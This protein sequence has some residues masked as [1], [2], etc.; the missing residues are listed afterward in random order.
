MKIKLCILIM[1]LLSFLN[2]GAI[3]NIQMTKNSFD[4][5]ETI[6]MEESEF[7]ENGVKLQYK[8][9]NTIDKEFDR[10]KMYLDNNIS[11]DY[12]QCYENQIDCF[13]DNFDINMKLW[14]DSIYTYNEITLI[15]KNPKYKIIDLKNILTKME[16][17]NLEDVQYF[18]YYEGEIKEV[19]NRE[20][21]GKIIDQTN[22]QKANILDINNGCTG[23]GYLNNGDKVNFALTNYN[24]GSY[25]IIG[26][27]IIFATY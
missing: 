8:T 5:L 27:P 14:S 9:K 15:N 3:C 24:T 12:K 20:L 2:M 1:L 13:N 10:V 21:I 4:G 11:V 22:I 18:L 17:K 25:V 26:T 16:N 7:K 23:T 6:A 19:N